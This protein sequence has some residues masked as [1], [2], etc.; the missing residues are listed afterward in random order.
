MG[1]YGVNSGMLAFAYDKERIKHALDGEL[2]CGED[3]NGFVY[4]K[5]TA[6]ECRTFILSAFDNAV[7]MCQ[8]AW[9]SGRAHDAYDRENGRTVDFA[10]WRELLMAEVAK[11]SAEGYYRYEDNSE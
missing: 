4:E 10:R 8:Q 6:Q 9:A 7:H 5:A 2:M 11:D 3:E 1:E